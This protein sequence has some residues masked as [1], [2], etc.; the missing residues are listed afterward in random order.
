MCACSQ[1]DESHLVLE[2]FVRE[3]EVCFAAIHPVHANAV[4]IYA[5]LP[6]DAA[7]AEEKS[8]FW[9]LS[10]DGVTVRG[11]TDHVLS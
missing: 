5:E 8:R 11:G 6:V 7:S 1:R 9:C 4:S 2:E 10:V 3:F